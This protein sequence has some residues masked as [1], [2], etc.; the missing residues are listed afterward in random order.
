MSRLNFGA[1]SFET[2]NTDKVLFPD[3]GITKGGLIRYYRAIAPVILPHLKGRPLTLHR[4]PDG[5]DEEGFYQQQAPDYFPDWI[6]T[7]HAARADD[8]AQGPVEHILCNNEATLAYLANQGTIT[9]HGWLASVPKLRTPDKLVFD[10]DPPGEDFEPVRQ[11]ARWVAALIEQLGLQ[12]FVMTT[13][14][15]GLHVVAPLKPDLGFDEVRDLARAMAD[16]LAAQHAEELTVAQRKNKRRGRLY[17][18][19]M[20][21]AYGQTSVAPYA[22]RALP[23]APVAAPLALDELGDKRLHPQR[24][25]LKNILRRLGQKDD[26]WQDIRRHAGSARRARRELKRL[27]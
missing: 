19:V 1:Y 2:S 20:R 8:G 27:S 6:A 26:P 15:R 21:N 9:L 4:F 7:R 18:D 14:S 12:P 17:L 23:G 16:W 22:V 13:G 10:L 25:H 3:A 5:I 24:W 11:G